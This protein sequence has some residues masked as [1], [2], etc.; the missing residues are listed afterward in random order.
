[1]SVFI[2]IFIPLII[3]SATIYFWL[4]RLPA[5]LDSDLRAILADKK[6]EKP[7]LNVMFVTA[8]PDDECMFFAPTI[9]ALK[10][11]G[12]VNI[13]LT[14][15]ST[16]NAAGLGKVRRVELVKAAEVLGIPSTDII[17][18]DDESFPDDMKRAW[19]PV[20]MAKA[21]EPIVLMSKTDT[22]FTFDT[23]GVSGHP[24]HISLYI[25]LKFMV[26]TGIKFKFQP[27]ALFALDSVSVLRKYMFFFDALFSFGE[28][29]RNASERAMFVS[30][31]NDYQ[32]ACRAM[33]KH[34]SQMAWFRKLYLT[35][36]RYMYINTYDQIA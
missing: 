13:K 26:K 35:F 1:M 36:S 21:L 32:I 23:Q 18:I 5:I 10:K 29:Y 22:I 31:F 16:G 7:S 34:E 4:S 3:L 27:V 8:H 28:Y 6:A 33:H 20:L 15:F 11:R 19:D 9:L 17:I 25:G 14:C 30:D 12:N 24:N 2:N